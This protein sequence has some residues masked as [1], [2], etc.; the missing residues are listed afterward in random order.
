L[1]RCW[2]QG[3]KATVATLGGLVRR[4]FRGE[5]DEVIDFEVDGLDGLV[6]EVF[7]FF[8]DV[9]EFFAGEED[10]EGTV[11]DVAETCGLEPCFEGLAIY[12]LFEGGQDLNPGIWSRDWGSGK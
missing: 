3:A 2:G 4:L 6:D 8:A 11:D 9:L 1:R 7:V 5:E 12:L 10:V